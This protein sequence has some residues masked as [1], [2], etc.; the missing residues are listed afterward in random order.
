MQEADNKRIVGILFFS[1]FSQLNTLLGMEGVGRAVENRAQQGDHP[2]FN[3]R[4]FKRL[5]GQVEEWL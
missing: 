3:R 5:F 1:S 4:L 2:Y